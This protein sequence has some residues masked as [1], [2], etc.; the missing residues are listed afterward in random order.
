METYTSLL[1]IIFTLIPTALGSG[2]F[3][4]NAFDNLVCVV[5]IVRYASESIA[6]GDDLCA[7]NLHQGNDFCITRFEAY[8]SP[9]RNIQML[10][11]CF[12]AIGLKWGIDL[13]KVVV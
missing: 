7:S 8:D 2:V 10:S 3:Q 12:T 13:G 5:Q 4:H 6:T 11:V 9:S 1:I